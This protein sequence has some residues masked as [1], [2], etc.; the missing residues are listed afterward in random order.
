[1]LNCCKNRLGPP[2]RRLRGRV[3][4]MALAANVKCF[5]AVAVLTAAIAAAEEVEVY[6]S[7]EEA[8]RVLFP[9]A[10]SIERRDVP[11]TEGLRKKMQHLI[12]RAKPSIWEPY[13]IS[14]IAKR[15]GEVVGYAVICEE[16]GKH[17]PITFIVGIDPT[18]K[19]RDVAVMMY[20]ESIG[21]EIRYPG[22]RRQFRGKSLDDPIAH[23]RDI[24]NITGATLSSRAMA[25]GV[26]KGLAFLQLTYLTPEK[27]PA[28]GAP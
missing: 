2:Q 24:R 3:I 11:A 14:F 6:L 13:Y 8:P 1:M 20:R 25:V 17:R 19:I 27:R 7:V 16:I 4:R 12:G 10:D 23:R 18:G 15:K 28:G 21:N 22:F 26:R 9:E 5:L